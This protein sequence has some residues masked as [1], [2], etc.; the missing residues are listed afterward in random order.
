[1]PVDIYILIMYIYVAS[2][3][4]LLT[5]RQQSYKRYMTFESIASKI[6]HFY[7]KNILQHPLFFII[8]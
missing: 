8:K 3:M 7:A 4:L 1:M 2:S 6:C 5:K